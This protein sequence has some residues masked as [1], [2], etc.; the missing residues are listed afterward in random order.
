MRLGKNTITIGL[1]TVALALAGCSDDGSD[2][3]TTTTTTPAPTGT[4]GPGGM[5]EDPM[6]APFYINGTVTGV[7]DCTLAGTEAGAQQ[8]T[9]EQLPP[10]AANATYT[11]TVSGDQAGAASACLD[12]GEG[13]SG[14]SSGTVPAT[15]TEVVV[16][17]DG[18]PAGVSY[19]ILFTP[20]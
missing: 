15:A 16:A 1:L 8:S 9:S 11:L 18:A 3:P 17:A 19:S 7:A 13:F 14:S 5:D 10:E 4:G 20:A 12:F 6:A 2:D